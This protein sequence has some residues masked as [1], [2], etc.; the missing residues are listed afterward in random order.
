MTFVCQQVSVSSMKDIWP[1]CTKPALH[2]G[3]SEKGEEIARGRN[4]FH[5]RLWTPYQW[6][7]HSD[8]RFL[9]TWFLQ[10]YSANRCEFTFQKEKNCFRFTHSAPPSKGDF[11]FWKCVFKSL[12]LSGFV[13]EWCHISICFGLSGNVLGIHRKVLTHI[14]GFYTTEYWF[15]HFMDEIKREAWLQV[16]LCG[17]ST[18]FNDTF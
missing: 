5:L 8:T 16:F 14:G 4:I 12:S 10:R 18:V 3:R 1:F 2:L 6:W 13:T 7:L 17:S 15:K 9:I 11:Y